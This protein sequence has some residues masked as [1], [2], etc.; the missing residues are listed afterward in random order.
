MQPKSTHTHKAFLHKARALQAPACL[1]GMLQGVALHAFAVG[2]SIISCI[3][4]VM[5]IQEPASI[6]KVMLSMKTTSHN[7]ISIVA[8]SVH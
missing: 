1:C 6:A 4:D 5:L 2:S 3:R 8:Q 7:D